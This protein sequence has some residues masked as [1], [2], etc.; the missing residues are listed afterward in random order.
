MWN[1]WFSSIIQNSNFTSTDYLPWTKHCLIFCKLSLLMHTNPDCLNR[2]VAKKKKKSV[3][4]RRRWEAQDYKCRTWALPLSTEAEIAWWASVAGSKE[5]A[6]IWRS[7]WKRDLLKRDILLYGQLS[8]AQAAS[9]SGHY[10]H[11][12]PD[13]GISVSMVQCEKIF[14]CCSH[15]SLLKI[16][17][18]LMPFN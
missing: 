9:D 8:P 4:C 2:C 1:T 18:S 15:F 16:H 3:F 13:Y 14:L 11:G 5:Q 12:A 6:L 17:F 7:H 10:A